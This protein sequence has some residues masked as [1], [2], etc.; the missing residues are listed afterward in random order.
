MRRP[1]ALLMAPIVIKSYAFIMVPPVLTKTAV[2][3]HI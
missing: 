3:L 1:N 2:E